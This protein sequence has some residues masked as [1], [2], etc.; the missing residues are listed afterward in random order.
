MDNKLKKM[1]I[2]YTRQ[3]SNAKQRGIKWNYTFHEW[4]KKWTES[5]KWEQRGRLKHQYVMCRYNDEGEY[6]YDNTRIDTANN[7]NIEASTLRY[8]NHVYPKRIKR[9]RGRPIG[10]GKTV[11]I[12]KVTYSSITDAAKKL[13]IKRTT[14]VYRLKMNLLV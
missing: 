8:K 10:S 12:N 3:K 1:K 11:V 14:L 6:S 9:S 13:N 4:A 5:G 7:N 2:A